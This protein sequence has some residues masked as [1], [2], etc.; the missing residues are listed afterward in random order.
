MMR[1]T[2]R[3][4]D[5]GLIGPVLSA[6]F[7]LSATR[8]VA[9]AAPVLPTQAN[10]TAE[11]NVEF[12]QAGR[13]AALR[14]N[15]GDAVL[16]N[17]A[18]RDGSIEYDVAELPSAAGME[19]PWVRFRERDADTAEEL[20]LRPEADCPHSDD[21]IQYAP[22]VHGSL[23]WDIYPQF[24]AGGPVHA[25]GWNHVRAVMGGN[26]LR[27]YVNNATQPTLAVD[28]LEGEAVSGS[29]AFNGPALYR[30]VVVRP[31]DLAGL[32]P[33]SSLPLE[34]QRLV[35]SW[36]I[37]APTIVPPEPMPTYASMPRYP[38]DW[39][40]IHAEP[41]GLVNLSRRY[42][43]PD[44]GAGEFA[45]AKTV[46]TSDTDQ[47]K[48]VRIGWAREVSVFVNGRPA[49]ADRNFYFGLDATRRRPDGRL[50]LENGA[51]VMRLHRGSN[52]I[53][54]AVNDFF[55]A[56][57]SMRVGDWRCKSRIWAASNWLPEERG[58]SR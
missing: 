36:Q 10:W 56:V 27:V 16:K 57:R 42:A 17:V 34:D 58:A 7:L 55:P 30:N 14:I 24:Q 22:V 18:F 54:V 52:E 29:I 1:S 50:S 37:S 40:S 13:D 2:G 3:R 48:R 21:C 49:F 25:T 26:R 43:P 35:R 39:T 47:T 4:Q 6:I 32:P 9:L 5:L 45:W 41:S 11:G 23:L 38:G 19:F 31:G 33:P 20:Y 46:I 8:L 28:T 15:S 51:F 53:A 44:R 12:P